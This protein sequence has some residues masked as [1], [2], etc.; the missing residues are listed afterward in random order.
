MGLSNSLMAF[1]V[2]PILKISWLKL[3]VFTK[4][5]RDFQSV[6]FDVAGNRALFSTHTSRV[7]LFSLAAESYSAPSPGG[8]NYLHLP[9]RM[10]II[11]FWTFLNLKECSASSIVLFWR[12]S[13]FTFISLL[14]PHH[15]WDFHGIFPYFH[16]LFYDCKTIP[17]LQIPR[18]TFFA[19]LQ[20]PW[21]KSSVTANTVT[22]K[23]SDYP[24]FSDLTIFFC[25]D[26]SVTTFSLT[27]KYSDNPVMVWQGLKI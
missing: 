25:G 13:K 19:G 15:P 24:F 14:A 12:M 4:R 21:L 26:I 1:S 11:W 20:I 27:G 3:Q 6:C 17:W 18:P 2:Y 9:G 10:V 22:K 5:L 23:F 16:V 7:L 8:E